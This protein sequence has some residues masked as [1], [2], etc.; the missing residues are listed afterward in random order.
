M[1]NNNALVYI[2]GLTPVEAQSDL[3]KVERFCS[4]NDLE[5]VEILYDETR[6]SEKDYDCLEALYN[7]MK[8]QKATTIIFNSFYAF[9][10]LATFISRLSHLIG[11]EV[12]KFRNGEIQ[13]MLSETKM[14][15]I[16]VI[17]QS[18][19]DEV[20]TVDFG[21]WV[22]SLSNGRKDVLY[23]NREENI[24]MAER[25]KHKTQKAIKNYRK[26]KGILGVVLN[27]SNLEQM[28]IDVQSEMF[29]DKT[30]FSRVVVYEGFY[31]FEKLLQSNKYYRVICDDLA[32]G[33]IDDLRSFINTCNEY[34]VEAR[35]WDEDLSTFNEYPLQTFLDAVTGNL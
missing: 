1:K 2:K 30:E 10:N 6:K 12:I 26:D 22:G 15:D 31:E 16:Q 19:F 20:L 24:R 13:E 3:K 33:D 27:E 18:M 11:M 23:I 7:S 9:Y 17:N 35:F 4:E 34:S 25:E 32:Y 14:K 5:I 8:S 29:L 28:T 21:N